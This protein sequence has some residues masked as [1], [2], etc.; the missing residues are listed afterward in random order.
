MSDEKEL[1]FVLKGFDAESIERSR[2]A[3]AETA[4]R[5]MRVTPSF[6]AAALARSL[7]PTAGAFA[8]A[9]LATIEAL[10][11]TQQMLEACATFAAGIAREAEMAIASMCA[12]F[13]SLDDEERE[14]VRQ[15]LR[16]APLEPVDVNASELG[17]M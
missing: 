6:D 16:D 4:M 10:K 13:E 3:L 7:Q 8:A 17:E 1:G 11:P 15:A 9:H 14:E 2:R 5:A 12:W